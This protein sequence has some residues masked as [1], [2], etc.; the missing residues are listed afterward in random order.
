MLRSLWPSLTRGHILHAC[1]SL[2]SINVSSS[3]LQQSYD[4]P[5]PSLRFS[6]NS[7]HTYLSPLSPHVCTLISSISFV[8]RSRSNEM[9]CFHL[10]AVVKKTICFI[11][12]EMK[13]CSNQVDITTHSSPLSQPTHT[14]RRVRSGEWWVYLASYYLLIK[15]LCPI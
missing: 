5:Y 13:S 15:Y 14:T 6:L 9:F 8:R 11:C 3:Y 10:T 1:T 7:L 2:Q 12:V 4:L